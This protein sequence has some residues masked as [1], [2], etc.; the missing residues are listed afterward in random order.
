MAGTA[1]IGIRLVLVRPVIQF[2]VTLGACAVCLAFRSSPGKRRFWLWQAALAG[3]VAADLLAADWRLNPTTDAGV[4]RN[5]TAS[6]QAVRAAGDGRV[7]WFADDETDIKFNHYL[8]FKK[9]GSEAAVYWLGERETLLPNTA[10]IERVPSANNFDSLLLNRYDELIK[11]VDKLPASDALRVAGLMNARYI[12]SPRDL[13]LPV[14]HRGNEVTIYRNDAATGRAWIVPQARVVS[15]SLAA[16]ADPSFDP[17]QVVQISN[18]KYQISSGELTT[19]A[20]VQSLQD[21]PN[22]VTIRAASESGGFLVLADTFYPDW[23]A[24][25]DGQLVEILRANH[26]FR[27]VAFPPGEHTVVFQYTPLSFQVGAAIS[28]LTLVA[29]VGA[30][31]VLSL[32]R[33][34]TTP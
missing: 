8:S 7:F 20:T 10:M 2:G 16:L 6:A 19:T 12:V 15:D 3:I 5:S 28:L 30:L 23:R 1:F 14:V 17:R 24:T 21:S 26:A 4:Y 9:L 18:I 11:L 32:R 22:A 33:R 29:V 31:I 34:A 27:A 13:A 25:L